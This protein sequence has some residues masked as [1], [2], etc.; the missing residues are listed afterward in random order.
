MAKPAD[1][2]TALWVIKRLR[3]AGFDAL[4]AGGCVRDMLLHQRCFDYD[5]ATSATP[6]QVKRLFQHVL[7]IGAKFGV[8]MVIVHRR[9]VEVTTFRSDVSYSDGRHPDAVRFSDPRQD[10]LRRDFTINGMF[11]D[12][13]TEK[14]VDYVGGRRDLVRRIIRT[15]GRPEQRFT[16]DYLRMMRAVRFAMRLDFRVE[17]HTAEAIRQ[18]AG[19]IVSISGERIFDELNKILAAPSATAALRKLH[20]TELVQ[21]ILPELFAQP[22]LWPE[23]LRR[24]ESLAQKSSTDLILGALL[25]NL[26]TRQI[27]KI[28]R[29][30]GASNQRRDQLCFYSQHLSDWQTAATLPLC[31]FKRWMASGYFKNLCALWRFEE[32]KATGHM[33]HSRQIARRA[34]SITPNQISPRPWVT[35]GDLIRMGLTEGPR[36]GKI[37]NVL[38]DVQLN[39]KLP[40]RREALI[41]ARRLVAEAQ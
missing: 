18:H 16:E 8:A 27:R 12:P 26:P 25:A 1:K 19:K 32:R 41:L 11:Y 24:V 40:S 30:W 7:L 20:E 35:G 2:S 14:V 37:F 3:N 4:L 23:A 15:I 5:V 36:L 10:A 33:T 6:R 22:A 28:V 17:K 39:E 29:R 13:L 38:Y 9:K 21:A 31:A 34:R